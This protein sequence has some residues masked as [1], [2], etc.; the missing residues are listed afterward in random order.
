MSWITLD[1][2]KTRL[3]IDLG[4]ATK[5]AEV[6][7]AI[8]YATNLV[9]NYCEREFEE[10]SQTYAAY[11]PGLEIWLRNWPV[12]SIDQVLY[13]DVDQVPMPAFDL[14]PLNGLVQFDSGSVN[15]S[16]VTVLKVVS[17]AGYNPVPQVLTDAVLDVMTVRYKTFDEDPS[18]G[19]LKFERV[20]GYVSRSY[21]DPYAGTDSDGTPR[22]LVPYKGVI[23]SFRSYR[24]QGSW[25][26]PQ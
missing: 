1:E 5:D 21:G 23:D 26:K 8:E 2:G 18:L 4:D 22:V 7:A 12:A 9:E 16:D 15:F 17:T 24:T 19:P 25:N 11:K 13:D 3:G 6:Q 10:A 14:N 20:D